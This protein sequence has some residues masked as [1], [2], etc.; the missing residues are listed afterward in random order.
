VT[1]RYLPHT[2][3][4][5]VAIEACSL[6]EL[7]HDGL[8][9]AR[10]L[11]V[12]QSPVE[13]RT[14]NMV[15]LDA[16]DVEELFLRFLRDLLYRYETSGFI[17]AGVTAEHLDATHFAG[18]LVGERFDRT[19]HQPEPE[20]KAVTRHGLVVRKTDEGWYAEVLFDV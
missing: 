13:R 17:P 20:V 8:A 19:R 1:Y 11:F 9:I 15:Q 10:Q 16:I 12:G 4:I 18:R 2:A 6:E 5:R 3:D 14:E 7:F